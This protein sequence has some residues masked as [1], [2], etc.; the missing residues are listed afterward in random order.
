M[1]IDDKTIVINIE[2][3]EKTEVER[4]VISCTKLFL[5][6]GQRK[7]MDM[8]FSS[9]RDND[10][11]RTFKELIDEIEDSEFDMLFPLVSNVIL[12]AN[13]IECDSL[14]YIISKQKN[15]YIRKRKHNLNIIPNHNVGAADVYIFRI[16]SFYLLHINAFDTGSNTPGGS[17][18]IVRYI[19]NN[20]L[21]KPTS[22]IS[23]GVCY[24][25]NPDKQKF[26][27][28]IIPQKLYPWSVGQ[29]IV[30]KTFTIKNDDFNLRLFS[31]FDENNIYSTLRDF[32][33]GEDGKT[34]TGSINL[35]GS[36]DIQSF[37]VNTTMGNMSTGEAVVSSDDAKRIIV[38]ATGN[39]KE[40]GGEMEGYGI[41]KECAYYANIP[42]IIIKS[43][44][45]WGVLKNI[46]DIL[47][48]ERIE[49][50]KYLK[51]KLQSYAAFCAGIVLMN[52]YYKEKELIFSSKLINYIARSLSG[53]NFL[54]GNTSNK[55]ESINKIL[56]KFYCVD[57]DKAN[58][59]FD[60][61]IK[62]ELL[63]RS[64]CEPSKYI[65]NQELL[66]E[67]TNHGYY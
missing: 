22:I 1:V 44:C 12:T 58:N 10:N 23:F 9:I 37:K 62:K 3:S 47:K 45:D 14:N 6:S 49:C 31:L 64:P 66:N 52:L 15:A 28:V 29:K 67:V 30:D 60:L 40:L 26:G 35:V 65:V 21:L 57:N 43:I 2:K 55:K 46:D 11:G 39:Y 17:T 20:P 56:K 13:K 63:L 4:K 51:D 42:C 41:A 33:N 7:L 50:P 19:S 48:E 34:I 27:D 25:R 5:E 59:I 61:F 53:R 16:D 54:N 38:E 8:C 24:G 32:C 18:D 36:K